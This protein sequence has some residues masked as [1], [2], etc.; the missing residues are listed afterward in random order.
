MQPFNETYTQFRLDNGL[1][2]RL[3]KTSTES[4]CT[5]LRFHYGALHE[6][7]GKEG[8]AHFLEHILASGGTQK[9]DYGVSQ[10]LKD[11]FG[12]FNA[13]TSRGKT[14]FVID[15]EISDLS[16]ALD[17]LSQISFY[18]GFESHVIEQQRKVVLREIADDKS[19]PDFIDNRAYNKAMLGTLPQAYDIDGKETS[20]RKATSD[21]F[22]EFHRRGFNA[23]NAELIIVGNLPDN[24]DELIKAYFEG[25][26]SGENTRFNFPLVGPLERKAILHRTADDLMN[27]VNASESSANLILGFTVPPE[28]QDGFYTIDLLCHIL[29]KGFN[30]R[31]FNAV[32]TEKGL[33]YRIGSG[34]DGNDNFGHFYISGRIHAKKQDEAINLVF[35]EMNKLQNEPV[36]QE[37]LNLIKKRKRYGFM[38]LLESNVDRINLIEKNL[39]TGFTPDAY[40]SILQ[41][42]TPEEIMKT[43]QLYLPGSR[44]DGKYVL[45][46]RDPLKKE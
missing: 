3:Q 14:R 43:A 27:K 23:N 32:R 42:I 37:E 25:K 33:A 1:L 28:T 18:P 11:A 36:E 44:D 9:Y 2:V 10:K 38:K 31:L 40:L 35:K 4:F 45:L 29:G 21:D 8:L 26:P 46:L 22:N 30:S 5:S 6:K 41:L 15:S 39:E 24:T 12:Y 7:K 34:V 13:Y 17:F 19:Q 20:V 16:L